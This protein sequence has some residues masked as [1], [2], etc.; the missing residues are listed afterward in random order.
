VPNDWA[1]G[2]GLYMLVHD[3]KEFGQFATAFHHG[4]IGKSPLETKYDWE[5]VE[6]KRLTTYFLGIILI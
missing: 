1:E 2:E 3:C 5:K 6:Q 4:K